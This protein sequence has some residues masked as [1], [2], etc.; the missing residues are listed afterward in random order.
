MDGCAAGWSPVRYPT[1]DAL[2]HGQALAALA[3]AAREDRAAG[4]R[5]HALEEAV[6]PPPRDHFRLVRAL[7]HSGFSRKIRLSV[8]RSTAERANDAMR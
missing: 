2:H 5:G 1:Q 6:F 8:Y 3:A 4:A 7:G